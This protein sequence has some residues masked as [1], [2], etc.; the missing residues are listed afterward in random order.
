MRASAS[1]VLDLHA[2]SSIIVIAT[3]RGA[4]PSIFPTRFE[5]ERG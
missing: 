1:I 4:A 2:D 5:I 3:V